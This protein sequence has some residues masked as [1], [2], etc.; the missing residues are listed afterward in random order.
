[1]SNLR[2]S[3]ERF[4]AEFKEAKSEAIDIVRD[5][6]L[7]V[8]PKLHD[9]FFTVIPYKQHEADTAKQI[10]QVRGQLLGTFSDINFQ[11]TTH[12]QH[13]DLMEIL[14]IHRENL[15]TLR[16]EFEDILIE[17]TGAAK[18][19]P[20]IRREINELQSIII[21]L[22]KAVSIADDDVISKYPAFYMEVLAKDGLNE[23]RSLGD[24]FDFEESPVTNVATNE[25][26]SSEILA[27]GKKQVDRVVD[28]F[29]TVSNPS[30]E[31][32]QLFIKQLK[33]ILKKLD[34]HFIYA[35][36]PKTPEDH[37]FY[38]EYMFSYRKGLEK[39]IIN[40]E[41]VAAKKRVE[42]LMDDFAAKDQT[43]LE[44]LQRLI[45]QLK[46]VLKDLDDLHLRAHS[47]KPKEKS[48]VSTSE[49]YNSL[50]A[51]IENLEA[52]AR[53]QTEAAQKED[54]APKVSTAAKVKA[55][56][57]MPFIAIA[58]LFKRCRAAREK[59]AKVDR[60]DGVDQ[61][62][63]NL[64]GKDDGNLPSIEAKV[65][66]DNEVEEYKKEEPEEVIS[67]PDHIADENSQG[68]EVPSNDIAYI[69]N[70]HAEL[71]LE[72]QKIDSQL[73]SLKGFAE[74]AASKDRA[75]LAGLKE[76][77][78]VFENTA[79]KAKEIS[80][81]NNNPQFTQAVERVTTKQNR[82]IDR[83]LLKI[84][85]DVMNATEPKNLHSHVAHILDTLFSVVSNGQNLI[86]GV[87]GDSADEELKAVIE[88]VGEYEKL[89]IRIE[90]TVYRVKGLDYDLKQDIFEY[91]RLVSA[92][93]QDDLMG[94]KQ[95]LQNR[96]SE[97]KSTNTE[98]EGLDRAATLQNADECMSRI[99]D[100]HLLALEAKVYGKNNARVSLSPSI[101]EH[102]IEV[103]NRRALFSDDPQPK[104]SFF[105]F[106]GS[107]QV[108]ELYKRED[109]YRHE[110]GNDTDDESLQPKNKP[111]MGDEH[112]EA[113]NDHYLPNFHL[114]R[115]PQLL[116]EKAAREAMDEQPKTDSKS[117]K[118]E[119]P[120]RVFREVEDDASTKLEVFFSN[121]F[122]RRD[123]KT[124]KIDVKETETVEEKTK[125]AGTK[126]LES[127]NG[128]NT[129]DKL[130]KNLSVFNRLDLSNT[131]EE[132]R[133][134][135]SQILSNHEKNQSSTE[136][137]NQSS[138]EESFT[139][140][141]FK[142]LK[143][144]DFASSKFSG[145]LPKQFD[146]ASSR[147]SSYLPK[148]KKAQSK[149]SNSRPTAPA[150][151]PGIVYS[152]RNFE[153]DEDGNVLLNGSSD[154]EGTT[155]IE[156]FKKEKRTITFKLDKTV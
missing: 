12:E 26:P 138:T 155:D 22:A 120:V 31:D 132:K 37:K 64:T 106:R 129:A 50:E 99:I 135:I 90:K 5:K 49:Y 154:D 102:Q 16:E 123:V 21:G 156:K 136:E 57:L 87:D 35:T 29:K 25:S 42:A 17:K 122:D 13:I 3:T 125:E 95:C 88:E 84:K 111:E 110:E 98:F 149:K 148:T 18:G 143:Q 115:D 53:Q 141:D 69:Q 41:E 38:K 107:K 131:S 33:S 54:Q 9:M 140:K 4:S 52:A 81:Q 93:T 58:R 101:S 114:K 62:A 109:I 74:E 68:D 134:L 45:D 70:H 133:N 28:A 118:R 2:V 94:I 47:L 82:I 103:E 73:E 75:A 20:S 11:E 44:D 130:N 119:E 89:V 8:S 72:L 48:K 117:H 124:E 105:S 40:L 6:V 30:L 23:S 27:A 139:E 79:S 112:L 100:Q 137:K 97:K 24:E 83:H 121:L 59:S 66:K 145:Y 104:K 108:E 126:Q 142:S 151:M 91:I 7:R 32:L 46:F 63:Q 152:E 43:T 67:S 85:I 127:A 147:F 96:S 65:S 55:A 128:K 92:L 76:L 144:F 15:E 61:N 80:K 86:N 113:L 146:F 10:Q 116:I 153:Y 60:Q 78:D 14:S 71:A 34:G 1:M 56:V 39:G 77:I 19:S 51:C 150:K 36:L